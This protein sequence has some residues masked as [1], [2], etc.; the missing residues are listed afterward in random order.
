MAEARAETGVKTRV[1]TAMPS[2][3]IESTR[4][5]ASSLE[6]GDARGADGS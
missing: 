1:E 5:D 2:T 4:R 3:A 6:F